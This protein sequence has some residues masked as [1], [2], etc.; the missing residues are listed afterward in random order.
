MNNRHTVFASFALALCIT[1]ATTSTLANDAAPAERFLAAM[2]ADCGKA[3]AGEIVANE[4]A[5]PDDPF[6]GKALVMHIRECRPGTV[7]VPFHVGDDR[8]RT[9]VLTRSGDGLHLAHDHRH[10]D[11]SPETLTMYGG[12]TTEAGSDTVQRFPADAY[13]V[14]LFEREGRQVSVP[15]VWTI[16]FHPGSHAIYELAR[17]GRLFRVRFDLT[18]PLEP[19]AAPWGAVD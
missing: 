7:R 4:P 12:R 15:N 8:S 1:P 16:E 6:I 10:E 14:G 3:Y 13:S 17:P 18:T 2:A 5:A 19:P 9:W 11:G